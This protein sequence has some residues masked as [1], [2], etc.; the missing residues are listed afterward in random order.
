MLTF[1][2]PARNNPAFTAQCLVSLDHTINSLGIA[3]QIILIDNN[4][5][6]A[7]GI[8]PL[9]ASFLNKHPS[10]LNLRFSRDCSYTG[11]FAL[12]LQLATKQNVIFVSNDMMITPSYICTLLAVSSISDSYGIIRGTSAH[13]DSFPEHQIVPPLQLKS[14][15]DIIRF[16]EMVAA[17]NGLNHVE[18][19]V[20]AGDSLLIKRQV[21]ERIGV[22]DTRFFGYFGDI[23]YGLRAHLAG[24]KLICA[25]GAWLHH[26]GAGY[27]KGEA[28][29]NGLENLTGPHRERMKRVQTAY[30]EFRNKWDLTLPELYRDLSSLNLFE[31]A[32]RNAHKVMLKCDIDP[33]L[34]KS[35][36]YISPYSH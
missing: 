31:M 22:L 27:L 36:D 6:P 30:Q 5:D 2:I 3:S 26:E 12:G 24:F 23:D 14:Y 18:D 25:K 20:V 32:E 4:S 33:E 15:D 21:I 8:Q 1:I 19:K 11:A 7:E 34:V 13:T 29:A 10:S 17:V 28:A 35:V 9:F 16:S